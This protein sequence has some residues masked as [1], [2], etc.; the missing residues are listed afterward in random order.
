MLHLK[1][2]IGGPLDV[3]ADL[4]PVSRTIKKRPQDEHVQRALKKTS[5]LLFRI[6]HGRQSTLD[7]AMMV[8]TR[9]SI[10]KG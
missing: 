8:D 4:V 10:V 1:E 9:L 3:L 6:L 7:M 5:T 2:V